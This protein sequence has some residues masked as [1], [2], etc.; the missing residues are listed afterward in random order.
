MYSS[1]LGCVVIYK[2]VQSTF[3]FARARMSWSVLRGFMETWLAF[4]VAF[5]DVL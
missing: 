4:V 2:A 1:W 5:C 3:N